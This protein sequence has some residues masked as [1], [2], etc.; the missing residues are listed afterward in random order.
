MMN[1]LSDE[2]LQRVVMLRLDG[3]TA[4]EIGKECGFTSRWAE[5]KLQIIR[6]MWLRELEGRDG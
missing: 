6:N 3:L 2:T 5:R 4:K 1:V